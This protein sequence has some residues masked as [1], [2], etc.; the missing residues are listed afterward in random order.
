M[1]ELRRLW[2][3]FRWESCTRRGNVE[4]EA[5][6]ARELLDVTAAWAATCETERLATA[7]MFLLLCS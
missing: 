1:R 2:E 3:V 5:E 6:V 7:D 4:E